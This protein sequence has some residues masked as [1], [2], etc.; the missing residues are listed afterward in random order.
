M[1]VGVGAYLP[2]LQVFAGVP[3]VLLVAYLTWAVRSG[4]LPR[5]VPGCRYWS[6]L[7]VVFP[8]G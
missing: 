8:V 3:T 2:H 1:W 6:R 4:R 7:G 5:S